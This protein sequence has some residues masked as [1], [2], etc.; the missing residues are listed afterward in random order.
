MTPPD[1]TAY[2][3][4]LGLKYTRRKVPVPNGRDNPTG[5]YEVD[6]AA[7]SAEV[8]VN[9]VTN[10]LG[11]LA[12]TLLIGISLSGCINDGGEGAFFNQ[13]G[14]EALA[15]D[16]YEEALLN[17]KQAIERDPNDGVVWGNL[18]VALTRLERY[19]EALDAYTHSSKLLPGDPI[20]MAEIGAI[21]YRL[22]QY[23]EAE[24]WF[25][26]AIKQEPRAAEFRSS[27]ALALLHLGK[28]EAAAKAMNMATEGR[29]LRPLVGYHQ[30]A[31]KLLT[32]DK[33]GGL[34]AFEKA[35][36]A[37]PDA[38]RTS[39]SDHDFDSLHDDPR[40]QALVKN[41]WQSNER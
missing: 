6:V 19:P 27:L 12:L 40:Y 25:K 32:G 34:A 33:E 22:K 21:H 28:P 20:T 8:P 24:S 35:I 9:S 11:R 31:Y 41:W 18:G 7:S 37:Y 15:A 36:L 5:R 14:L 38:R 13:Q 10:R 16:Q 17:F 26:K 3:P 4:Q 1:G 39:L 2:N 30:A 23:S 29:K